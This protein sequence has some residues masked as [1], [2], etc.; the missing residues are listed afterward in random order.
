MLRHPGRQRR[1][2]CRRE[3]RGPGPGRAARGRTEL[4]GGS[5]VP[6]MVDAHP[7]PIPP[8]TIDLRI[9]RI[10]KILGIQIERRRILQI[11]ESLGFAPHETAEGIVSC[12]IPTYRPDVHLEVDLIEEIARIYGL[13]NIALP[14]QTLLQ[15]S[16]PLPRPADLLR[17]HAH[18]H[19]TGHG[20]REIYTNSLLPND[21]ATQFS[22]PVL[23]S[24]DPPAR[25]L[26][27][28]SKSMATL[29]PSLLPGMLMAMQRNVNH[30]QRV[31]RFYEFGHV[32]HHSK[33]A[34]AYIE[35]FSEYD[36]LLLGVC[37]AVRP[38][39]W[40]SDPRAADFFDLKGDVS[41][42]LGA[43]QLDTLN[44]QPN[45]EPT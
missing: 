5:I 17:E 32:F 26:N 16:I 4:A 21:V 9:S 35:N 36:V 34:A 38:I 19:L 33:R 18:A 40:D 1:A 28:V 42:L 23:D 12:V 30:S 10:S 6:G 15:L 14:K 2:D 39:G 20:F 27:A 8:S 24:D 25:T 29:R 13:E 11:L 41:Q 45:Y 7:K 44:M 3:R 31:L 43:L 22:Q 37:G